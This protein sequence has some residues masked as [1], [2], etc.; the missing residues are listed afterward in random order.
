[1]HVFFD[2]MLNF[3]QGQLIIM[4]QS[5]IVGLLVYGQE[6][7]TIMANTCPFA[8]SCL[9]YYKHDMSFLTYLKYIVYLSWHFS[10]LNFT[11]LKTNFL[12]Q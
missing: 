4:L 7:H 11:F 2:H 3:R 9:T 12:F 6:R 10:I 5:K 8:H 1:M